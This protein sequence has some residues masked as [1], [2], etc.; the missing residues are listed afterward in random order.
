M[1]F[2]VLASPKAEQDIEEA[3]VYYSMIN[4]QLGLQ[5]IDRLIETVRILESNPFFAIRYKNI[6]TVR[7]RQFPYLIHFLVREENEKV[8]ILAVI[9]AGSEPKDYSKRF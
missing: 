7:L 8:I 2:L 1:S 3:A 6:R 4:G 9:Y 5:F